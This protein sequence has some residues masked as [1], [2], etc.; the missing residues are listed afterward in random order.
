MDEQ[1]PTPPA[2]PE[3]PEFTPPEAPKIV[4]PADE[5]T[6]RIL[7]ALG[8]FIWPIALVGLLVEPYKSD[9][10]VRFH[11]VQALALGVVLWLLIM[12]PVLG[13]LVGLAGYVYLIYLAIK[14]WSGAKIEVPLLY[15]LVKSY[16]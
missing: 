3:M 15:D 5:S 7:A 9:A 12:I 16:I 14:A 11:A 1:I 10:F 2:P 6:G 8:Y 4:P 13:W